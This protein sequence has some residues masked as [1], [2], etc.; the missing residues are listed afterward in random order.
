MEKTTKTSQGTFI[1][2]RSD[3]AAEFFCERCN[4]N[5]K[6]KIKVSHIG[7]DQSMKTIC[8]GCYGNLLSRE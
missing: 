3:H 4:S 7:L 8:N 6:S 1:F 2:K 5:K